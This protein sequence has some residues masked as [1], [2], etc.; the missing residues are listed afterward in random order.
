MLGE[1]SVPGTG[2]RGPRTLEPGGFGFKET[3]RCS[4]AACVRARFWRRSVRNRGGSRALRVHVSSEIAQVGRQKR[5]SRVRGIPRTGLFLQ[6]KK[7]RAILPAGVGPSLLPSPRCYVSWWHL[8]AKRR[9]GAAE[10]RPTETNQTLF[11]SVIKRPPHVSRVCLKHG[12]TGRA[13][14]RSV[15]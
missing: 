7:A 6:L 2:G 3:R 1:E 12:S 10:R 13:F 4:Q 15:R 14:T 8:R 5:P 9:R 11:G